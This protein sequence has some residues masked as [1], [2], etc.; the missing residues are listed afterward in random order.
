MRWRCLL[1]L[2][3]CAGAIAPLGCSSARVEC[4]CASGEVQISS[5]VPIAQLVA[6]GAACPT[7][8]TCL[9]PLDGGQC[10]QFEILYT[11]A[12]TCHIVATAADGRQSAVDETVTLSTVS[13]CCGN[14]YRGR[15]AQI[16]LFPP[17]DAGTQPVDAAADMRAPDVASDAR[18]DLSD[19]AAPDDSAAP[20]AAADADAAAPDAADAPRFVGVPLTPDST[21]WVDRATTGTTNIQGRWYGFSDGFGDDGMPASGTCELQGQHAM[22]DCS[23]L[24]TPSPGS[25]PNINGRMCTAGVAARVINSVSTNFPDYTT[26]TGAG[27]AFSFNVSNMTGAPSPYNAVANGVKGIGFDID[28]VPAAGIRVQFPTVSAANAPFWGGNYMI[29]PVFPGHNEVRWPSVL[30]PYFDPA[31]PAFDVTAIWRVEFLVPSLTTAPSP[32]SFCI[33]NL[34]ALLQ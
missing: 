4:D 34:S 15:D 33:S 25:F 3:L 16:F 31:P 26:I 28:T 23:Q 13:S 24:T 14:I 12:G 18:P 11:A 9:H 5:G 21:G 8:T 17:I 7:R 19:G 29:S 2:V 32:F 22:A 27:I 1:G 30:G 20:D 6:S 10:D